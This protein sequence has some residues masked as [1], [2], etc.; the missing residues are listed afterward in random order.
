MTL[1][2]RVSV[3]C[4][5]LVPVLASASAGASAREARPPVA[6]TASPSRVLLHGASGT[7]IRI[8]NSG[9]RGV[10]VDVSRAGFALDLRGRPKIVGARRAR[11]ATRWLEFRPRRISLEPGASGVVTITSKPPTRA[12]PGDHDALVLFTTRRRVDNGVAVRM[13][14]G[15]VVVVRAPG[16]VVRRVRLGRP[17]VVRSGR[18]RI[19]EVLVA[20]R[21][22]VTESIARSRAS[23]SLHLRGR[24]LA[25]VT[26]EPREL[27]PR[28]KGLVQFIYRGRAR[29]W[30]TARFSISLPPTGRVLRTTARVRLR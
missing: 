3:L 6:L 18:A 20:N 11:S 28:T 1:V 16:T 4:L 24:R 8:S 15:V 10:S 17:R 26:A 27:R 23:V 12:E 19:L 29:G 25:K 14:L 30:V 13:R 2:A 21:G 7:T 5:V 22:N 9:T